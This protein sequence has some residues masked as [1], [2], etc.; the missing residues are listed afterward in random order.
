MVHRV[1]QGQPM[2]TPR[3]RHRDTILH[4][5]HH[6]DAM[7]SQAHHGGAMARHGTPWGHH[8]HI[9]GTSWAHHGHTMP[10]HRYTMGTP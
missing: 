2:E 5:T 10:H 4:R 3:G 9:M 6:E 7:V 8:G 1:H